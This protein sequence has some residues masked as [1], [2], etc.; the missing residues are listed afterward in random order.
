LYD[1]DA[2]QFNPAYKKQRNRKSAQP[3]KIATFSKKNE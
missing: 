3:A 2:W 1:V